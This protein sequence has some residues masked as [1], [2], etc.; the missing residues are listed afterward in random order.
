MGVLFLGKGGGTCRKGGSTEKNLGTSQGPW[1]LERG[2][3]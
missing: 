2:S 3:R 1:V